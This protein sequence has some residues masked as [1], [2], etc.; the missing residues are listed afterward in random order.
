M[1]DVRRLSRV[2]A[3]ACEVLLIGLPLVLLAWWAVADAKELAMAAQL[4]P[5]AI[6]GPITGWQRAGGVLV[7]GLSVALL[8]AGLWEARKCFRLFATGQF[9]AAEAVRS[10]RRFAGW[11]AGSVAARIV[12][13]SAL[14]V[15]LTLHNPPGKRFL[16]VSV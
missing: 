15:L 3:R 10:L 4:S 13:Q 7:S 9:F 2:L 11:V 16:A 12:T 5:D 6:Q 8:L 14:S 1:K